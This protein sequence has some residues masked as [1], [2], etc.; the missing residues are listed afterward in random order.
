V[1]DIISEHEL[2]SEQTPI[3]HT[4]ALTLLAQS[5]PVPSWARRA[6]TTG[7]SLHFTAI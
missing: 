1:H 3:K 6:K 7:L 4:K 5:K 2:I